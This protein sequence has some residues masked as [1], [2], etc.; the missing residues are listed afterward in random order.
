MEESDSPHSLVDGFKMLSRSCDYG[1]YW[2]DYTL[3]EADILL[4][5]VPGMLPS[6]SVVQAGYAR[7]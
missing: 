7:P 1:A 2:S 4:S 6:G 5:F 3:Y